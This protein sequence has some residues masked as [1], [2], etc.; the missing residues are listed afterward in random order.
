[1]SATASGSGRVRGPAMSEQAYQAARNSRSENRRNATSLSRPV[2]GAAVE[3]ARLPDQLGAAELGQHAVERAGVGF[4]LVD[5]AAEDA[6]A[7]ALTVDRERRGVAHADAGGE[8]LP[9]GFGRR[10]DFL[11]LAAYV[12][13]AV[14][15]RLVA[16]RPATV[17]GIADDR[18]RRL[19]AELAHHAR[20]L[21]G[22]LEALAFEIGAKVPERERGVVLAMLR[23]LRL[24][25]R[26]VVDVGGLV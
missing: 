7:V 19:G 18:D 14:D 4:L 1:M 9:F 22:A 8:A 21:D 16:R 2:E 13:E 17:E 11:G 26:C 25:R 15:R 6:F 24:E 20:H 5:R 23:L 3:L 12:E 10:E